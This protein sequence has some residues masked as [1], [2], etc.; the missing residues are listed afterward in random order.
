VSGRSD[1]PSTSSTDS[2]DPSVAGSANSS[3]PAG[4]QNSGVG[5]N[6]AGTNYS[7]TN[8]GALKEGAQVRDTGLKSGS[9]HRT[10]HHRHGLSRGTGTDTEPTL[11]SGSSSNAPTSSSSSYP[12][13]SS[14][15]SGLGEGNTTAG[16]AGGFGTETG[17]YPTD[18]AM[19]RSEEHLLVGKEKVDVGKAELN[20]YVTTERVSTAVPIM[21]E[22]VVIEREPITDANR[23]AAMRGPDFKESHY[24]VD[25]ME[26]RAVA[27]KQTVP[28]ER[29][30]LRK[31]AE[32]SQQYVEA[33][34]RKE[35]IELVDPT[36]GTGLGSGTGTG[37]RTGLEK[38]SGEFG[39]GV[40]TRSNYSGTDLSSDRQIAADDP[41]SNSSQRI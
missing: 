12:N 11:E 29:V 21:R 7:S 1:H 23:E 14:T 26:E 17:S 38:E 19:T 27:E 35:H 41:T 3:L 30:R 24:E 2:S 39:S 31:E 18:D 4:N 34:L 40:G 36:K 20:K 33:D 10:S 9:G 28:I 16:G 15:A 13:T 8:S 32:Q 25:L 5:T 37:S 6:Y 22:K